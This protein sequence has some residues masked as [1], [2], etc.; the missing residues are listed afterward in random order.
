[1]T[2]DAGGSLQLHALSDDAFSA[3]PALTRLGRIVWVR[4]LLPDILRDVQRVLYLDADV[5]VVSPLADLLATPTVPIA[6]VAN[7]VTPEERPRIRRLGI[8]DFRSFFNA[9][10]ML[11]DLGEL[12][13]ESAP[14]K[15]LELAAARSD[16]LSWAD[17]DALNILFQG[18]WHALHPR[19]NAQNALWN[20]PDVAADALGAGPA[21]EARRSP[22]IL[23]FEGPSLSKPWHALNTHPLRSRWWATFERTPWAGRG[24]EDRGTVTSV[25]RFVPERPRIWTYKRVLG[26]RAR[27]VAR[28]G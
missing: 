9:G 10:V 1:M 14:F 8:D 6:A 22:A 16:D 11:M 4:C 12:R 5:L 25:L 2:E 18:R 24:P 23:H 20:A 3:L 21:E 19:W 7:V 28:R 26:W 13:I 27:Q 15:L 17:Q